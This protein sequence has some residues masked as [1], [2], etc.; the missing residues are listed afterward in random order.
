MSKTIRVYILVNL[1]AQIK[2]MSAQNINLSAR[3]KNMSAHLFY[4]S[5]TLLSNSMQR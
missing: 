5:Q 3:I 1:N 4:M 2:K